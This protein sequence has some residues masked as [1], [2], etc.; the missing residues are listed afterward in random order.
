M[1]G[2]LPRLEARAV[3]GVHGTG[4]RLPSRVLSTVDRRLSTLAIFL[5]PVSVLLTGC[6]SS[7]PR[8]PAADVQVIG[9]L[10]EKPGRFREPRAI[11]VDDR[12]RFC[13]IDRS[14]RIQC[15]E[16][17]GSFAAGWKLPEWRNGQPTGVRFSRTGSLIVADSH[18][19]RIL[20]Y[21]APFGRA[22]PP[23]LEARF[24]EK[25][26][27]AGQFTLVRDIV[28]DSQGLLYAGDYDGPE[29][30][31]EKFT[32]DGKF[33][34]AWG[35]RG[36]GEGEFRRP[37]GMA[38]ER[39]AD[40]RERLLVADC[41][42]HRI[43]RFDLDGRF[44]GTFGRLGP[45]PGEMKYP[46]GVAAVPAGR[47]GGPAIYVAEWGN[48]R[49]QR[50]DPDGRPS[51]TWGGPGHGPGELATPWSVAVAPDGKVLVTDYGNHR[52]QIFPCGDL[53]RR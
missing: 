28:E 17:D 12:G 25:G 43:Q 21:G 37:Q 38:I 33:L 27:G 48:N 8:S 31:I 11:A 14:G 2:P 51:G 50:F 30:R 52:I 32:P 24:G 42:N 6:P 13:V 10:G 9:G 44:V 7:K 46:M 19:Q 1:R 18:Y 23:P 15:F 22:E 49:I 26:D 39:G 53:A 16:A 41:S 34:L 40:G 5:L 35:R 29:D 36:E 3:S 4:A 20:V 47:P 45:G